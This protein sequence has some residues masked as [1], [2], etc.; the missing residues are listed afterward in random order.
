MV[1]AFQTEP[2]EPMTVQGMI[3]DDDQPG[4]PCFVGDSPVELWRTT[5]FTPAQG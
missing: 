4:D 2:D 1:F 3:I 5:L